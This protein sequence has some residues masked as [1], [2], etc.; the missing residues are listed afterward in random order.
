MSGLDVLLSLLGYAIGI[1]NLWRF[2]YMVGK[3]GGCAFVL[4][5][6][7]CLFLV[8]MPLYMLELIM[9]QHTRKSTLG[10]FAAVHPQ[11]TGVAL[12]QTF[13]LFIALA[14][15]N[16]LLAYSS[17]Y[18]A[19]SLVE[20]LPWSW[21]AQQVPN[22]PEAF[23]RRDVLNKY[24]EGLQDRGLGPLQWPIVLA[25]GAVW[26][27][28]FFSLAF[29]KKILSKVTW[30]TVVGPV[31]L[32]FVL[33]L[34]TLPLEG[35]GDGVAFY[36]GKFDAELLLDT[37]IWAAACGQ[38]LF[39][40]SPGLGTAITLASYTKPKE[41][42]YRTCIVVALSNSAF[43][44]VGGFAIFG[45]LGNL[46]FKTGQTV[47][48]V[49][50]RSGTGLAFVAIAEGIQNFGA[51]AN[52]M[53]VLFFVMLLSLGLDSTFAWAETLVACIE[54]LFLARGLRPHR[55]AIVAV[56]CA[57]LFLCG[58]PYCTRMGGELLDVLDH[59][60]T[61]YY[62]LLGCCLEAAMFYFSFGWQRLQSSL[63]RATSGN[64]ATPEG[65]LLSPFWRFCLL[66]TVPV[67]TGLLFLQLFFS[68]VMKPYMDYPRWM[69][70]I[71][72]ASFAGCLL[73]TLGGCFVKGSSS[74]E[75]LVHF[76]SSP[77]TGEV[78]F[79]DSSV[80]PAPAAGGNQAASGEPAPCWLVVRHACCPGMSWTTGS[81]A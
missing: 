53:A 39:S 20:P 71:G 40:L 16:V 73:L 41:D 80:C 28:V 37:K 24:E 26:I 59:F 65:R 6:L 34:R 9:G 52:A 66:T 68:D 30:V 54:D 81:E 38:I 7:V 42:V 45:I 63:Q 78:D 18:I 10:C 44:L 8:A 35:V 69:L 74:L 55:K 70:G 31:V 50:S 19:G 64:A 11:W 76:P 75:P 67:M 13:M 60:C 61:S 1:G 77:K 49:A 51:G 22:S 15:Y 21:E 48:E 27:L 56:V 17:I 23:W 3:W 72:W 14:Y 46:A 2:P 4:A 33:L 79:G 47:A 29:G 36:I 58:L 62:L 5:Y 32:L 25:L 43:S 12:A 57:V